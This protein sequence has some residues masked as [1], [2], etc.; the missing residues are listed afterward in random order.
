MFWIAIGLMAG[1]FAIYMWRSW[2]YLSR[3]TTG[4]VIEGRNAEA[5]LLVDMQAPLWGAKDPS[6]LCDSVI[7]AIAREAALAQSRSSPVIALRHDWWGFGPKLIARFLYPDTLVPNTKALAAP[8]ADLPDHLVVK[9]APDGF[10]TGELDI[11]L[12]V[13]NVGRL[14]IAGQD[15][16]GSVTRTAQAA[17]NRGFDV[18][19]VKDAIIPRDA[20]QFEEVLV[21]LKGQGARVSRG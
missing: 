7:K 4:P 15:R 19:L 5:L 10:E 11:V 3:S 2:F 14:R 12:R 6:T 16:L 21:A 18:V 20:A 1:L 8:F 9:H 13:L 17:L